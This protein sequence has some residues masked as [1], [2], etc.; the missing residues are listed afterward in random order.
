MKR[1]AYTQSKQTNKGMVDRMIILATSLLMLFSASSQAAQAIATVSKNIVGINEVF[2]LQVTIDD[3]VSTNALD[4]SV[5]DKDFNYGT[6]QVSSSTSIINGVASRNT[7][8]SVALASK[9]TGELTIPSFRIGASQTTPI[10][11]TSM[12]S[13][14][15]STVDASKP[16]IK[17]DYNVD[18]N[19][20]YIG[21]TSRYTVKIRI[22]EQMSQAALQAPYGDGL[23]V[24]Q[25]GEDNQME[26]VLNGRRYLIITRHYQITA[27]KAGDLLLHGA[28][29]SGTIIKGGRGFGSTLRIPFEEQATDLT[30]HVKDKPANYKGLWLPT[31]SLQLEQQWQPTSSEVKVGEPLNRTITLRIKNAEQSSLPNINL[32]YPDSVR[33]YNEKPVYGNDDG[34]T[35]MT[36]KQVII[37]REEGKLTLPSLSINWWN[38]TTG[39]QQTSHIDGKTLTILPGEATTSFVTSPQ[40]LATTNNRAEAPT[41]TT[42]ATAVQTQNSNWWPWISLVLGLLWFSTVILWLNERKRRTALTAHLSAQSSRAFSD[43]PE[44]DSVLGMTKALAENQPILLQTYYQQ[45]AKQNPDHPLREKLDTAISEQMKR[46]Y[47]KEPETANES[48]KHQLSSLLLEL[49]NSHYKAKNMNQSALKTLIP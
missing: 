21:E 39:K 40:N 7:E 17:I 38:T 15:N 25:D 41:T 4:L 28:T 22:G 30:M 23:E 43:M 45:W 33:V 42:V 44:T 9:K 35:T 31:E 24:K 49:K 47:A 34:Y 1:L 20:L 37:P 32:S 12:K 46:R 3:N 16:D 27:N 48:V 26:A 29:F 18:K 5:L 10:T 14:N 19:K 8:W 6:P 13:A 2:Q 36:V 11:I